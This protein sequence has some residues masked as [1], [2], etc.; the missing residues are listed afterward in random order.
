[1]KRHS[2]RA[3]MALLYRSLD[4]DLSAEER[5]L[6]EQ[7]LAAS[8]GLRREKERLVALRAAISGGAVDSFGPFFVERVMRRIADTRVGMKA[9]RFWLG[10]VPALRRVAVAG[11]IATVALV[12]FNMAQ[13]DRVS[14]TAALGLPDY[15][16]EQ[17]TQPGVESFLE[18]LS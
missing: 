15:S 2:E 9:G 11:A 6:L 4:E 5:S 12:T 7:A 14:A 18:E 1:M 10:W 16:V 17:M 8:K 3:L 13:I